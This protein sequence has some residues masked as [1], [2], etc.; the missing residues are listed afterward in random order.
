MVSV[1]AIV[2][3]VAPI[4][5]VGGHSGPPPGFFHWRVSGTQCVVLCNIHVLV[6][7]VCVYVS[8]CINVYFTIFKFACNS[9][10]PRAAIPLI[11]RDT[12]QTR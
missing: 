7:C 4:D 2:V 3:S 11:S 9:G 10:I 5:V 6:Q 12:H 8:A 1:V